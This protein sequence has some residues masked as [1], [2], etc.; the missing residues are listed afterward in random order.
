[1]SI[2][3]IQRV[4]LKIVEWSQ[5]SGTG[6]VIDKQ[7]IRYNISKKDMGPEFH[8]ADLPIRVGE[9]VTGIVVDFDRVRS[10]AA[11]HRVEFDSV[12]PAPSVDGGWN[13]HRGT[14]G[15]GKIR[16]GK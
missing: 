15:T 14:P 10:I 8:R 4:P 1:M 2:H 3:D 11:D 13:P 7:D 12:G 6:V 9:V 16:I 5:E